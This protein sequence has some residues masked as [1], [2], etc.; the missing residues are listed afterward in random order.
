MT[1]GGLA[2]LDR[3][4][5]LAQ[6]DAVDLDAAIDEL[7]ESIASPSP[8]TFAGVVDHDA[9]LR[10]AIAAIEAFTAK[11][12]RVRLEHSLARDTSLGI[13]F[14]KLISAT[15]SAY[16]GDLETLRDRARSTAVRT[17]PERADAAADSVVAAVDAAL[18]QRAR[19]RDGVLALARER[20]A[21]LLPV[22]VAAAKDPA[23]DDKVRLQWSAVRRD[24]EQIVERPARLLGAVLVDRLAA[25][26]PLLDEPDKEPERSFGELIELD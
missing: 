4:T 5:S 1:A 13:P 9:A 8:L 12:T 26:P 19:L 24:L 11:S 21:E 3:A 14:M 7:R 16:A 20:A 10:S 18:S 25:L 6:L 17:D 15:A 22:V 2:R 23:K